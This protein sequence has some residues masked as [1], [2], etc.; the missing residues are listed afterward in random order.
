MTVEYE[1]LAS[2]LFLYR[3]GCG[4]CDAA[5][6][7]LDK[8]MHSNPRLMVT[9]LDADGP[10]VERMTGLRRVEATP[11][12]VFRVGGDGIMKVGAMKAKEIEKWLTRVTER[13]D[14]E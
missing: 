1:P 3:A 14:D 5:V 4:A 8:F 7:E 13:G 11:V 9:K 2:L 12:Y 6:P 10:H